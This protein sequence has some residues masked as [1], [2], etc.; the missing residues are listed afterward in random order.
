MSNVFY[1]GNWLNTDGRKLMMI[2]FDLIEW[3]LS[4]NGF[5]TGFFCSGQ[6][7]GSQ[8][9]YQRRGGVAPSQPARPNS[10]DCATL[11]RRVRSRCWDSTGRFVS[12]K[13]S[14][15]FRM[16][17][18]QEVIQFYKTAHDKS[19]MGVSYSTHFIFHYNNFFNI[20]INFIKCWSCNCCVLDY[21]TNVAHFQSPFQLRSAK[22]RWDEF[23]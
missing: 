23:S 2:F 18:S 5:L 6:W 13:V 1:F 11:S 17:Y 7:H 12:H 22:Q 9:S 10:T 4:M 16:I 19:P 21:L 15:R 8:G 14:Q 3:K 20:P